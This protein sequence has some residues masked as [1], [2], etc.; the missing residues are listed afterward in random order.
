MN[1]ISNSFESAVKHMG[2]VLAVTG[3]VYPVTEEN[4]YLLAELED[5]T[6][7]RGESNIGNHY[8]THPGKI[9]RVM[10]DKEN[11]KPLPQVLEAIYDADIIVLGPGSLYTSIIPNIIGRCVANAIFNPG[12]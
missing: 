4:V 11:V 2:E 12:Q 10:F 3:S 1:G 5:G 8:L 7:I 6:L 9:R